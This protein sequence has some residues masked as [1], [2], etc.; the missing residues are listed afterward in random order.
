MNIGDQWER[1]TMQEEAYEPLDFP[2]DDLLRHLTD[3]YFDVPNTLFPVLHRPTFEREL[4]E[5]LHKRDWYFGAVVLMVC[6][7]ASRYTDDPRV[8]LPGTS[9]QRSAGWKW[10]VT[11]PHLV[12]SIPLMLSNQIGIVSYHSSG[13]SHYGCCRLYT[14]CNIT[15]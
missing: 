1:A 14:N 11:P 8:L 9:D 12:P 10:R 2:D 13:A 6:A 5:G 4:R 15:L 7:S 3:V